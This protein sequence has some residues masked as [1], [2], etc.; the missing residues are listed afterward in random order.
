MR[1]AQSAIKDWRKSQ[2]EDWPI[3]HIEAVSA[4]F[5]THTLR[6]ALLGAVRLA[7][8]LVWSPSGERGTLEAGEGHKVVLGPLLEAVLV[9][10]KP[11][12]WTLT[13]WERVTARLPLRRERFSRAGYF[14]R[15]IAR[16]EAASP[17]CLC[18]PHRWA[19]LRPT[20]LLRPDR[21]VPRVACVPT[22]HPAA[23]PCD[24]LPW[25]TFPASLARG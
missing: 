24:R 16:G 14:S 18:V 10:R 1:C 13:G 19:P 21:R 15:W 17:R 20:R 22:G 5:C 6:T 7:T 11:D 9:S 25:P 8:L 23:S 3:A 12:R 4:A 2:P